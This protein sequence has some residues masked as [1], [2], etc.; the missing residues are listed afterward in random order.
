MAKEFID[1]S[2][3]NERAA[4]GKTSFQDDPEDADV[5]VVTVTVHNEKDGT[6]TTKEQR[7]SKTYAQTVYDATLADL[8]GIEAMCT[9]LGITIDTG[10]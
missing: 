8:A 5:V 1:P 3:F 9:T 2:D 4:L 6:T 10:K 7:I